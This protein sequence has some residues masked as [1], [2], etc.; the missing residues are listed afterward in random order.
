M[1][2]PQSFEFFN[3]RAN[4]AAAEAGSAEL[5]NV[6]DRALRSEKTWRGL[7]AQSRR[8]LAE[9]AKADIARA[10]R[11]EEERAALEAEQVRRLHD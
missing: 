7:A 11:R 5:A 10:T 4:E 8:V 6:R 1:A 9:R 2:S 3:L